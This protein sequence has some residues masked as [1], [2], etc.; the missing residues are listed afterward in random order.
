M[1]V[2]APRRWREG[3]LCPL[4]PETGVFYFFRGDAKRIGERRE[5][6]DALSPVEKYEQPD[7]IILRY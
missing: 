5:E 1:K 6:I 7:K 3:S 2:F 4:P